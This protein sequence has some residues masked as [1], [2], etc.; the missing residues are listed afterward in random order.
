LNVIRFHAKK[1]I[2]L[3]LFQISSPFL[4]FGQKRKLAMRCQH[5]W[6]FVTLSWCF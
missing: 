6:D 4:E 1:I 2:E 3:L 5:G